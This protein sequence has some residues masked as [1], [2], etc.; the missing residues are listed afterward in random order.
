MHPGSNL[1]FMKYKY[2]TL[3]SLLTTCYVKKFN[4]NVWVE[5]SVSVADAFWIEF[6]TLARISQIPALPQP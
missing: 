1:P 6:A 4:F 3:E 2:D 5:I